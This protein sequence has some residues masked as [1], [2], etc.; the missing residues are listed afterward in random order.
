MLDRPGESVVTGLTPLLLCVGGAGGG[1]EVPSGREARL[2][3]DTVQR[4]A[5]TDGEGKHNDGDDDDEEDED[6]DDRLLS[7]MIILSTLMVML[8]ADADDAGAANQVFSTMHM[9]VIT[10]SFRMLLELKR[11][12]YVT[13]TNYLELVKG[14]NVL[15]DEKRSELGDSANKLANGLAKLEES[16][17]QVRLI[18]ISVNYILNLIII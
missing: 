7:V 13:P 10:A 14:Y 9:S 11:H 3:P 2:G 1:H 18:I 17:L 8:R 12:N 16:R 5:G 6:E 15:L 4:R